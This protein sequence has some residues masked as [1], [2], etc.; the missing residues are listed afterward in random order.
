ML[1]R[2]VGSG[3]ATDVQETTFSIDVLGRYVCNT[4]DEAVGNGGAPFD[5]VVVGAGMFGA[6]LAAKLYGEGEGAAAGRKPRILVLEAGAFLTPTHLQ[7]LPRVGLNVPSPV[8]ADPGHARERVWGMPWHSDPGTPFTGLAYVVGGRSVYWGGWAPRMEPADLASWPREARDYLQAEGWSA[9]EAETGV[10]ERTDYI[11]GPFQ[12]DLEKAFRSAAASVPSVKRVE[13]APLAVQGQSPRS[14]LFSFDKFSSAAILVDAIRRDRRPDHERRLFLV[15]RVQV[16]R[17][18]TRGARVVG[19]HAHAD[20]RPRHLPLAPGARVVLANGTIEATRLAIESFPT[21]RMGRNLMGHLR[22]NLVVRIRRDVL[23]APNKDVATAALLVRGETPQ[24]RY[25]I[26]VTAVDTLGKGSE[27]EM[28]HMV[29]DIDLRQRMESRRADW[30]VL[31]LRGIGEMRGTPDAAKAPDQ[32]WMD[33]SPYQRDA[34]GMRRAWVNLVASPA[35]E[36]LWQDME[37]ASVE[38]ARKLAGAPGNVEWLVGHEWVKTQP[39]PGATRDKLGTTHHEAGTLWMGTDPDRSVTDVDGR[40][41]HVE[42]AYVAGP[43]LFPTMGSANPALT[44]LALARRTAK[45][46]AEAIARG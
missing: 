26:Q 24:G 45:R 8:S 20:G 31:T 25:H 16:T 13:E 23:T 42:N 21:P 28:W 7:N 44:A 32:S 10:A 29:P 33:L 41:H 22:S 1:Q 35:E 17:L 2:L 34:F 14:G 6:Y 30:V 11:N 46:L 43:A 9:V 12:Q 15:P 18:E 38:L 3:E 5:V 40:F 27:E 36:R 4:W 39:P 19:L 37:A